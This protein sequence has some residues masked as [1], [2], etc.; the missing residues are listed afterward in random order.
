MVKR[1]IVEVDVY[2]KREHY[3]LFGEASR[4]LELLFCNGMTYQYANDYIRSMLSEILNVYLQHGQ[5]S[6][7]WNDYSVVADNLTSDI[8]EDAREYK[9]DLIHSFKSMLRKQSVVEELSN[10]ED[11]D[12]LLSDVV[13]DLESCE[14]ESAAM[15]IFYFICWVL[16]STDLMINYI[17]E[18]LTDE[19]IE[20]L[21]RYSD[22][23]DIGVVCN[24]NSIHFLELNFE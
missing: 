3:D 9:A 15:N 10:A 12:M 11:L 2:F 20:T 4:L 1:A 24:I 14:Y 7:T 5:E 18:S 19:L 6:A 23:I 13:S 16:P 8:A 21:D 22:Y 17:I